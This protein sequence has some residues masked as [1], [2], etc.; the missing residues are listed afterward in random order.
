[1][2]ELQGGTRGC[3]GLAW[4]GRRLWAVDVFSDALVELDARDGAVVRSIGMPL[5]YLS[6]WLTLA[7]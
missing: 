7:H 2:E 3:Q 4:D 6:G 1:V 5:Q